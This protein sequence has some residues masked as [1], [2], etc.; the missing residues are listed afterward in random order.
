M[1]PKISITKNGKIY[2]VFCTEPNKKPILISTYNKDNIL[3]K[4]SNE[5]IEGQGFI[6]KFSDYDIRERIYDDIDSKFEQAEKLSENDDV[7]SLIEIVK[8]MSK[9]KNI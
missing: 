1:K 6:G 4:M 2:R 7:S 8:K 3:E 5:D 9:S